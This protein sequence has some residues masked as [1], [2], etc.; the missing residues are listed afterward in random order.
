MTKQYQMTEVDTRALAVPEQV[1]V[2][3]TET[4]GVDPATPAPPGASAGGET[5]TVLPGG[6]SQPAERRVGR[7]PPGR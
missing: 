4:A 2:A 6:A 5:L 7:A 3:M 1:S